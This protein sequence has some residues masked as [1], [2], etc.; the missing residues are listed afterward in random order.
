MRVFISCCE[1]WGQSARHP[2]VRTL[3][4]ANLTPLRQLPPKPRIEI[5]SAS[6]SA[7]AATAEMVA[8]ELSQA[9]IANRLA[10]ESPEVGGMSSPPDVSP[11]RNRLGAAKSP[12]VMGHADSPVAWQLL[13]DEAVERAKRENKLIFLSIGYKGCHCE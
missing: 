5:T 11:L 7:A 12:Y 8:S 1:P 13:D 10:T 3:L 9:S 4:P 6:A 2:R